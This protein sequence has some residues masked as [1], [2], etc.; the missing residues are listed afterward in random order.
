MLVQEQVAV[1]LAQRDGAALALGDILALVGMGALEAGITERFLTVGQRGQ[2]VGEVVV[3]RISTIP[4]N[5]Q[6]TTRLCMER[7]VEVGLAYMD[8]EVTAQEQ[9]AEQVGE[10]AA[11]EGTQVVRVGMRLMELGVAMAVAVGG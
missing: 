9:V 6:T 11:L 10:A 8:R 7:Q 5:P 2:G 1:M 3:V 4:M